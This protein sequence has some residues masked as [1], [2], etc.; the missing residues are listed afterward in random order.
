VAVAGVL[1]SPSIIFSDTGPTL[2]SIGPNLRLM[3]DKVSPGFKSV[4][5]PMRYGFVVSFVNASRSTFVA[6]SAFGS[7]LM[8]TASATPSG[9]IDGL[10]VSGNLLLPKRTSTI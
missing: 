2:S 7:I 9:N 5:G 6:F 4:S 10:I 1:P 3:S 8:W